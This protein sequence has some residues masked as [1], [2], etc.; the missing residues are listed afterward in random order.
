[1]IVGLRYSTA[2]LVKAGFRPQRSTSP[3]IA[4]R[5]SPYAT[6]RINLAERHLGRRGLFSALKRFIGLAQVSLALSP[7]QYQSVFMLNY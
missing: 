7:Q 3:G 2:C 1:M 6:F 5:S 4:H